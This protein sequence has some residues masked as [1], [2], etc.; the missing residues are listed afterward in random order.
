MTE[1]LF[2]QDSSIKEFTA[3]VESCMQ[4]KDGMFEVI[5]DQTAFFRKEAVSMQIPESFL[6]EKKK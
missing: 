3:T 5:L 1:K 2:Y 4:G 6:W